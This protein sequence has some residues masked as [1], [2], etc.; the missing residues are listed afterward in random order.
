MELLT[1]DSLISS[2]EEEQKEPSHFSSK[3]LARCFTP[4]E[5]AWIRKTDQE[6]SEIIYEPPKPLTL[7]DVLTAN[8]SLPKNKRTVHEPPARPS[9]K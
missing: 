5:L 4:E 7:R 6:S 1:L 9:K 2:F 3:K 8:A